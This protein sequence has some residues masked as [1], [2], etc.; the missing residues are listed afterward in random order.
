MKSAMALPRRRLDAA[1][2]AAPTETRAQPGLLDRFAWRDATLIWLAQRV[3]FLALTYLGWLLPI[4]H[5]KTLPQPWSQPFLPWATFND[6]L[7][8]PTI[9]REGYAHL[10]Q[11]AF[12]P[13]LPL[14][15]HILSPIPFVSPEAAGLVAANVACLGAFALLRVLVERELGRAAARRTLLYMAVF[16]T[17][18]FFAAAYTKSL[19]L[20]LSVGAF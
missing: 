16:P 7:M 14:I 8:Y 6:G 20:L 4:T 13:L 2:R 15:E 18:L 12:F 5:D 11:A 10:W 19:F 3:A 1:A 9:A 17:A